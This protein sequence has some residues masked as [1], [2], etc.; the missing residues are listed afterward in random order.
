MSLSITQLESLQLRGERLRLE[1]IGLPDRVG[2]RLWLRETPGTEERLLLESVEGTPAEAWPA[3]PPLQ[4]ASF[5]T[6]PDG[7]QLLL[8][9]GMAGRSHWSASFQLLPLEETI[10][11]DI[12]CRTNEPPEFLGSAYQVPESGNVQFTT[13]LGT[14]APVTDNEPNVIRI[15]PAAPPSDAKYPTT[16]RWVYRVTLGA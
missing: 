6:R 4:D 15:M 14:C 3:S 7:S 13:V 10:E 8:L 12:A 1:L 16:F 11:F 2:H 5:E 9:V